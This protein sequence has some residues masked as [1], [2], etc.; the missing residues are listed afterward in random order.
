[1]LKY[2]DIEKFELDE[3]LLNI[4]SKALSNEIS[5]RFQTAED[6]IKALDGE[7]VVSAPITKKA[8]KEAV[9]EECPKANAADLLMLR[10]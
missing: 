10:V 5:D 4:I 9:A 6:F 7:I 1:M 8:K 2:P 3:N